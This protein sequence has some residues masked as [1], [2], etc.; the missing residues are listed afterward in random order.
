MVATLVNGEPVTRYG[1]LNASDTIEI[2]TATIRVLRFIALARRG[3]RAGSSQ[4]D[5]RRG[6]LCRAAERR[7]P[8]SRDAPQ[9]PRDPCHATPGR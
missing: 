8:R 1:P 2:G 7:R 4:R 5:R 9:L 6:G 3:R